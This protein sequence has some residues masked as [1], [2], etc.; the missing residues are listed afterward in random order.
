M[1]FKKKARQY[2]KGAMHVCIPSKLTKELSIQ[3]GDELTMEIKKVE[4]P[5]IN[6]VAGPE[7]NQADEPSAD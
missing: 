5:I 3:V 6:E 7:E 2:G 1:E 4:R